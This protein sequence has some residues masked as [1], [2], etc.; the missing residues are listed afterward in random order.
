MIYTTDRNG[1]NADGRCR[2]HNHRNISNRRF[3]PSKLRSLTSMSI[4]NVVKLYQRL[5]STLQFLH[6]GISNA[7][8]DFHL[9]KFPIK[10][11][12]VRELTN[13]DY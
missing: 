9:S 1:H 2:T 11:W 4:A 6:E 7:L 3:K 10:R 8:A 5:K 12:G 13:F